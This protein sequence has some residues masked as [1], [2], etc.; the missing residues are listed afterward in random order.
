LVRE[1]RYYVDEL[2]VVGKLSGYRAVLDAVPGRAF[3]RVPYFLLELNPREGHLRITPYGRQNAEMAS[4]RY[5][6]IER[7]G[8]LQFETQ[9]DTVLVSTESL[10]ALRSAYPNYFA[11]TR[12]FV[13]EVMR[14]VRA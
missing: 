4:E 7:Q 6:T 14:A 5:M 12:R 8:R 2:D 3:K 1:L 10:K 11:D 9:R 13:Q